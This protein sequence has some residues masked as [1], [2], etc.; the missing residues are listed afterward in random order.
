MY[1]EESLQDAFEIFKHEPIDSRLFDRM[2]STAQAFLLDLWRKGGLR[3]DKPSEAFFVTVDESNN[4]PS[5]QAK[6]QVNVKIGLAV[7]QP[8]EFIIL[9]FSVDKRALQAE[10]VSAGLQ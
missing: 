3:G 5:S 8:A 10:L 1:A 7:L 4:P 2:R 9:E 6:R